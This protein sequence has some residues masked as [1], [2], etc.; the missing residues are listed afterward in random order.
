MDMKCLNVKATRIFC[1][2]LKKLNGEQHITLKVEGFMPLTIELIR[3]NIVTLWGAGKLYS[4]SHSYTQSGDLIR[5]P[6]MC[7]IVADNRSEESE[8]ERMDIFP[9]MYQQDNL[10]I[11]EESI[12]IEGN[13]MTTYSEAWQHSHVSFANQWLCNIAQQGFLA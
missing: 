1:R 6:E 9:Q 13:I 5:D 2:L 10:G 7:F 8:F 12:R 4:L 3:E 11:Y